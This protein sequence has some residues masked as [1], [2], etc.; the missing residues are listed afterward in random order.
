MDEESVDLDHQLMRA[1]KDGNL[2]GVRALLEAGAD[3]NKDFRPYMSPLCAATY[4]GN[5]ETMSMLLS[6][7]A[8][9]N[10]G[11]A[12]PAL[13]YSVRY[14]HKTPVTKLLIEAGADVLRTPPSS[15]NVVLFAE[16]LR[17][18]RRPVLPLLLRAGAALV[19][20]NVVRQEGRPNFYSCWALVDKIRKAKGFD[21][22]AKHHARLIASVV[23]KCFAPGVLPH[24]LYAVVATFVSPRG[25]Y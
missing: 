1:A 13:Y 22:Y 25:G 15:N 10:G 20:T 17:M 23:S 14:G 2:E 9:P 6:A 16:A 8:D 19:T 24:E 18:G 3:P 12:T 21:E 5:I 4:R 11:F 7:G